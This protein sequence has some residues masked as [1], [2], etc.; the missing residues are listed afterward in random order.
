MAYPILDYALRESLA[1]EAAFCC[2]TL[3]VDQYLEITDFLALNTVVHY[4]PYFIVG[5]LL[6]KS[7]GYI[8]KQVL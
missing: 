6:K 2:L 7:G 3:I 8:L 1:I 5:K 4:L